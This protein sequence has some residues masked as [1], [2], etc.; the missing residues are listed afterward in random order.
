MHGMREFMLIS[1]RLSRACPVSVANALGA[2]FLSAP[3]VNTARG[4][5]NNREK[6]FQNIT[7]DSLG[8][9]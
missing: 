3:R 5:K 7:L 6:V 1:D 9:R 8:N 4:Q 2:F